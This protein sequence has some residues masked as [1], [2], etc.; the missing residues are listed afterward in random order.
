P[1]IFKPLDLGHFH[2]AAN[3][4]SHY[5]GFYT[6]QIGDKPVSIEIKPRWGEKLRNHLLRYTSG[7]HIP[8]D[9]TAPGD[10]DKN[11]AEWLLV[12]LWKCFFN[13]AIRTS[14]I[15]REYKKIETN[16]RFFRGRL[17]VTAQ[18]R[19][20]LT[21][22]SCFCCVHAPL[23]MNTTINRTICHV[24][25]LLSRNKQYGTLLK[26]VGGYYERLLSFGVSDQKVRPEEIDNIRY[27][28]M[29]NGYRQLMYFSK[30]VIRRLGA[31]PEDSRTSGASF[32]V[33][34]AEIWE[35]YIFAVMKRFLPPAYT[36][37][38]PNQTGGENLFKPDRGDTY[39]QVR[40]D[41][42]IYKDEKII[43][44]IDAKYKYYTNIGFKEDLPGAVSRSDLYQMATYLYHYAVPDIKVTGIFVSP[45]EAVCTTPLPLPALMRHENHRMGV[46]NMNIERFRK[47]NDIE[48]KD[49]DIVIEEK[50]F[51]EKLS[52][53]LGAE[54]R[55]NP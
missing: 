1:Y 9:S 48:F 31:K 13:K 42:L 28:R 10:G 23:T 43:A 15:P 38:N 26:D 21:D 6:T 46:I 45:I 52:K 25:K 51:C 32:F 30:A 41:F 5:I 44:V 2:V 14:Y 7:I 36:I 17:N 34:I 8:P 24:F 18:I 4:A 53:A 37:I 47:E 22:Q 29:T 27:T 3:R 54:Q 16:D 55:G 50:N 35:N 40:P 20:D 12:L 19:Q 33:D 39:R 49:E 11:S